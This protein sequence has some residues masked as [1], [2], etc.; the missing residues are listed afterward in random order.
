VRLSL[1]SS[2]YRFDSPLDSETMLSSRGLLMRSGPPKYAVNPAFFEDTP[3]SHQRPIPFPFVVGSFAD[4]HPPYEL[5]WS[6]HF[7]TCG[8]IHD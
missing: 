6:Q 1:F 5:F 3:A 7:R 8:G 4:I 2:F